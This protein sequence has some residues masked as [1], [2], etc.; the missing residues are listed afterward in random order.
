MARKSLKQNADEAWNADEVWEQCAA[1]VRSQVSDIVYQMTF[2][3]VQTSGVDGTE[4]VLT[5]PSSVTKDR[6]E[7]RYREIIEETIA[8]ATD[9]HLRPRIEVRE[10]T[11]PDDE[12]LGQPLIDPLLIQPAYEESIG[13]TPLDDLH[14]SEN[15]HPDIFPEANPP[16]A[17]TRTQPVHFTFD[18]F[19]IGTSNRFAHAAALAVAGEP[20]KHY[21]PLFIY[22]AAGLGKTHLLRAVANYVID[23]YPNLRVR[24]VS[25]EEFM[26]RFVGAIQNR[27]LPEFKQRYREVDVLLVDDVQFLAGKEGLQEEFFH[28]FNSIHQAGGQ[29]LLSSDRPPDKINTLEDRLRSRFKMGLTTDIQPPDFETRLAIL[30]KKGEEATNLNLL[31]PEVLDFIAG[32]ITNNIRELEGALTR[33]TAFANLNQVTATEELARTVLKDLITS[34]L[35]RPVTPEVIL[36]HTSELYGFSVVDLIGPSRRRPLVQVR[37]IAM[38]VFRDLTDLSFPAIGREFGDRDHTT[39]I[40]AVDKIRSLMG[41]RQEIYD[42]VTDLIAVIK[43]GD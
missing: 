1:A 11:G 8:E 36:R 29:I 41:S 40:H 32:N 39:V 42:Q 23:Q 17:A 16:E 22:G 10:A 19:V 4:I 6:I 31:S 37:Q 7:G 20:A 5:V 18:D 15:G 25:S 43:T 24:Y 13:S 34:N 33:I 30:R 21:N 12:L 3:S 2:S 35:P 26:N 28:T 38:Y 14:L 9:D 27:T